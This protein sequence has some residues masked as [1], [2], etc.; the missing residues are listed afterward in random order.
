MNNKIE[1]ISS[2][3][4]KIVSL[5]A[6]GNGDSDKHLASIFGIAIGHGGKN[7]LELG[8]RQGGT[9]LPLLSAAY[10]NGGHLTSIDLNQT[11]FEP[12]QKY[13]QNWTFKQ[14]DAIDFLQSCGPSTKF[15]LVYLDDWHSYDHVKKEL[16]LL[17]PLVTPGSVILVHDLMY[18]KT[19]PYY[20]SDLAVKRGQWAN[21]GPYRAVCELDDNFWE[22]STLPY[23]NGLTILRKK[24]SS[25]Y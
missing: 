7:F 14:S 21:G 3:I 8:V 10:L 5:T 16:S 17:D 6:T 22:F 25:L 15:D 24:Y 20:H 1:E 2:D 9:T 4:S 18:G 11:T 23:N 19:A 13:S 12:D